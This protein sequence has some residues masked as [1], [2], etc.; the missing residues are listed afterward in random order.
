MSA[1]AAQS[2]GGTTPP[3]TMPRHGWGTWRKITMKQT[4]IVVVPQ[5]S[6]FVRRFA[7]KKPMQKSGAIATYIGCRCSPR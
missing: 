7:W 5:A 3:S 4:I 2:S 6:A 1:A